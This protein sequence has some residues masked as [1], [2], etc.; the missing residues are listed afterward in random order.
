MP[1]SLVIDPVSR[2]EGRARVTIE[3]D[4]DGAVVS[5]RLQVTELRG[6][7]SICVG[8]PLGEMPAL[9][10]RICGICPVSH[11]LAAARAGDAILGAPPPPAARRLRELVQLAQVIQS[12]ALSFFYLSAP[13][14][15]LGHDGPPERRSILGLADA[16]PALAR[17]GVA[18]RAFGQTAIERIT[19]QRI[20]GAFAVPGGVTRPLST[21]AR[22]AIRAALPAALDAALRTL[23]WWETE[24]PRHADLAATCGNFPT[25]F[26]ALVGPGGR[27]T[28]AEGALRLVS[29]TGDL[30]EDGLDPAHYAELV[31]E[32]PSGASYLKAPSWRSLGPVEGS[33]RVGP[34]AR[35]N[36]VDSCGTPRADRALDRFRSLASG[37]VLSTFHAHRA[38]LVEIVH[39]LERTD[40][41]LHDPLVLD[42]AVLAPAGARSGEGVGACEAPRGTLFHRYAVDGDGLVTRADLLVASA[43]NALSMDRALLQ[44][45]RRWLDG[46]RITPALTNRVEA[47]LRAFDPCLS[48]STHAHGESWVAIRVVGPGG[49]ALDTGDGRR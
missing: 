16:A 48:C 49:L 23:Q 12:H 40:E 17:D 36:V 30:L 35:L 43:Q 38:R 14:L 44:A 13:D 33:Y 25:A 46:A 1:R 26:L 22:Q 19:G 2:I 20:H 45:S 29:A 41:L 10:A 7:E 47:T 18:L 28:F 27:L 4:G 37:P 11:F 21:E 6:F 8:R 24:E 34:L 32:Q 3:L 39:A 9:T 15:V 31:C 5:A 42:P